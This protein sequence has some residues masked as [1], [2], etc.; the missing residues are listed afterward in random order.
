SGDNRVETTAGELRHLT[1]N[2][3]TG[4][5]TIAVTDENPVVDSDLAHVTG[6]QRLEFSG[7][8]GGDVTLGANASAM[9]G[10]GG[11]LTID[12]STVGSN[13]FVDV[14]GMTEKFA[15]TGSGNPDG[16]FMTA[17]QITAG[18]SI[19]GGGNFGGFG[20]YV[21]FTGPTVLSDA[22]FARILGIEILNLDDATN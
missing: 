5:G 3:G 12:G 7:S 15:I 1:I 16:F 19:Q 20:D 17:A 4:T 11:T 18:S 13:F 9:V 2:G 6:V 8:N 10:P 14:V 21:Q 22:A